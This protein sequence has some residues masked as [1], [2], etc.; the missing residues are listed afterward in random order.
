MGLE[1]WYL[2][3]D[4]FLLTTRRGTRILLDPFLSGIP[5]HHL[6]PSPVSID[7]LGRVDIIAVTHASKDHLGETFEVMKHGDSM[8]VCSVDV[9]HHANVL[10]YSDE[11]IV[12]VVS[13]A[14]YRHDDVTIKALDARHVSWSFLNGQPMMGPALSYL[15][16]VDGEPTIYFGGDT[17]ITYDMKLF[18]ELYHPDIAMVGVGGALIQG[19]TLE[20]MTPSEAALAVE[21]LGAST[22][23]P[24]HYRDRQAAE[25][26]REALRQ[27]GRNVDVRIM[28]PREIIRF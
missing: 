28:E 25:D 17:S 18:G 1:M 13:G 2:G 10:G 26:F 7:E 27:K 6:K 16:Q 24:M 5:E 19:R 8:L 9:K 22:A 3:W 23:I 11:R 4:A 21:F 12:L 20:E 14:S 15:I